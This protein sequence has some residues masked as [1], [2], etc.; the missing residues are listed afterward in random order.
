MQFVF[1][2]DR[3][4]KYIGLASISSHSVD[5]IYYS[6]IFLNLEFVSYPRTTITKEWQWKHR[7]FEFT[8]QSHILLGAGL[9]PICSVIFVVQSLSPVQL[10]CDP[11][12]SSLPVSFICGIFQARILE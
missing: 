12:D 6:E 1:I 4:G 2:S 5:T 11:M 3:F 9:L 7:Q 10:F 8:K